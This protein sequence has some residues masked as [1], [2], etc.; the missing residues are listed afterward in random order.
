MDTAV[1][2][3]ELVELK[4]SLQ[5][6]INFIPADALIALVTY[7]KMVSVHE[8]GFA[9]CPKCYVFRGDKLLTT[10]Q[11]QEQ[12]DLKAL[13]DPIK[14]DKADPQALKRFLVP[15]AECEFALNS[16]LD[17]LQCDPW[18]VEQGHRPARCLGQALNIAVGLLEAASSGAGSRIVTLMGG[19]ITHGPGA[20]VSQ[21]LKERIRSHLDIQKGAENTKNLE[22][23]IKFYQGLADRSQKAGIVIDVFVAAVD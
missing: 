16:I 1:A 23:A 22:A 8:L 18:P 20:I 4:D 14:K 17:D 5:Q 3:E 15:A 2:S 19:P 6:S 21:S 10:T 9:D 7:G 11:I 13:N 12:L